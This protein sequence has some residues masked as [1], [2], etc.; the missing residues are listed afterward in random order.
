MSSCSPHPTEGTLVR[1][2]AGDVGG[3]HGPGS[4]HTPISFVHATAQPG[5]ELVVPW[6][7]EFNALVYALSGRGTIGPDGHPFGTGQLAVHGPGDTL[8]L[9]ADPA[10]ES[11]H[12][13]LDVLVLGGKPIGEPV[14]AH[15]PF[16]MNTRAQI[17][18]A[19][20]ILKPASSG[21]YRPTTSATPSLRDP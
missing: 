1:V 15:G 9:R 6:P 11:R 8:V 3:H 4:T 14:V 17:I 13:A 7:S 19:S 12:G 5:A 10:Q 16:V 21:R 2:I 20:R 18:A